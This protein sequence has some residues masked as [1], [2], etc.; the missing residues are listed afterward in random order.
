MSI[1]IIDARVDE[2]K[3]VEINTC[4]GMLFDGNGVGFAAADTCSPV[5]RKLAN[6]FSARSKMHPRENVC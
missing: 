4:A 1:L 3:A 2:L 6:Q 5:V